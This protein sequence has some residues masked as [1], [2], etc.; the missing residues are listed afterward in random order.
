MTLITIGVGLAVDATFL[1]NLTS[2][3]GLYF[4]VASTSDLVAKINDIMY[5]VCPL[6]CRNQQFCAH[7][8]TAG[9]TDTCALAVCTSTL[10][11]NGAT[12]F[13]VYSSGAQGSPVLY[14]HSGPLVVSAGQ[15]KEFTIQASDIHALLTH[16]S[17]SFLSV[18]CGSEC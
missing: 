9:T 16:L 8:C 12:C 7:M 5:S 4:P 10:L 14:D 2:N 17:S 18:L 1:R 13:H 3:S 15:T 11:N 6:V